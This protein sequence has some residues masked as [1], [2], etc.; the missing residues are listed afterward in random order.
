MGGG[1]GGGGGWVDGEVEGEATEVEGEEVSFFVKCSGT[2]GAEG[3]VNLVNGGD[4]LGAVEHCPA[5]RVRRKISKYE[6]GL[7]LDKMR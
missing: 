7:S 5:G 1:G 2:G 4:H 6:T 3:V